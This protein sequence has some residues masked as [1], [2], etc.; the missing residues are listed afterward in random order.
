MPQGKFQQHLSTAGFQRSYHL[1]MMFNRPLQPLITGYTVGFEKLE[2]PENVD[3]H[4][5]QDS[6][7][8]GFKHRAMKLDIDEVPERCS[9]FV[10]YGSA[11]FIRQ[12]FQTLQ[13]IW[14]DWKF[15][16]SD[17]FADQHFPDIVVLTEFFNTEVADHCG[18]VP[19]LHDKSMPDENLESLPHC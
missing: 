7:S 14:V 11:M 16:R 12:L 2:N 15:N 4:V 9:I 18:V 13:Q 17:T 10:F 6:I 5:E 19:S 3:I 8:A 1:L